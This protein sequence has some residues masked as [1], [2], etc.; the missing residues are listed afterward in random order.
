MPLEY[1]DLP[2]E[3]FKWITAYGKINIARATIHVAIHANAV[4]MTLW[5]DIISIQ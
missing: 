4:Y 5:M 1:C 3:V 2:E